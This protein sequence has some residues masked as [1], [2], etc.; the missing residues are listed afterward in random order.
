MFTCCHPALPLEARVALTLRTLGGLTTAEIAR[1]FLVPEPTMAQRLVRAKR[2]IRDAGIPYRVPPADLLPERTRG[3]AGRDLPRLQRGLRRDGRRRRSSAPTCAPRPSASA[4]CSS[5]CMPDEPEAARP[6]GVDAVA[7]RP[8]RRAG[9]PTT[10]TS[11]RWTNR[12]ARRGTGGRSPRA[13]R[14]SRRRCAVGRPARTRC[15]PPSPP[16]TP[17]HRTRR[18]PT[19]RRSPPST[20]DCR[21]CAYPGRRGSTAPSPWPWPT[22]PRL[23]S[24]CSPR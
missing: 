18:P 22:V 5:S 16:A 11:C 7:R 24:L 13:P 10:A 19:G 17:P 8:P 3:G 4:G 15:R 6:A 12:T 1:A 14:S 23:D 9:R 21:E 20:G 2:K